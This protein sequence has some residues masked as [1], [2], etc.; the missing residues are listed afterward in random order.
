MYEGATYATLAEAF[1]AAKA[2]GTITLKDNVTVTGATDADANDLTGGV[3]LLDLA[4]HTVY[5]ANNNIA[6]RVKNA[7]GRSLT[8][9]N[10]SD[11]RSGRHVLHG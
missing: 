7:Q 8:I 1:A 4:G 10:G 11:R 6:L 5:G 2:G 3:V 9:K